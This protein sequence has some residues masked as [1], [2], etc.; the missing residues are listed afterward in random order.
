[1]R[2]IFKC[3]KVCSK[4]PLPFQRTMKRTISILLLFLGITLLAQQTGAKKEL[5]KRANE[6]YEL[7]STNP[8]KAFDESEKIIQEAQNSKNNEKAE[9]YGLITQ[10]AYYEMNSDFK[11]MIT[12]GKLLLQKAELYRLPVYQV[13][14]KTYLSEAYLSSELPDKS[15]SELKEG[16]KLMSKLSGNDA[17]S[18]ET[19]ANFLISYSNYYY[20]IGDYKSQLKY[21]KLAG[22]EFKKLTDKASRDRVLYIHY[23]NLGGVYND[24]NELDSAE[25]YLKLSLSEE[26]GYGRTDIQFNNLSFLGDVSIKRSDYENALS[27]LKKAEKLNGY[28]NFMNVEPLYDNIIHSYQHLKQT[29]SAK[30]YMIKRDSLKLSISEKQNNSLH[31][32]LKEKK[33]NRFNGYFYIIVSILIFSLIIT[34]F[35]IRKNIILSKQEKISQQY[36]KENHES[37]SGEDYSKL[38]KALK[39]N[40]PAFMFYFEET[41]PGFSS[42]LLE[43]NPKLSSSEIEFCAL[44]KLKIHTKEIARY[45]FIEPATVR[46]K[47]YL[48]KRKFSI[49]NDVDIYQWFDEF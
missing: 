5:L 22:T 9:L 2:N 43:I 46:N 40:D 18:V 12:V 3:F 39:E 11:N 21:V 13:I 19:K 14:A 6:N 30:L 23:S 47:K 20:F 17:V 49:P 28:K 24:L 35:T 44:L 32:L 34:F 26:K 25:H 29:D 41:F 8:E 38:L 31:S 36:L 37:P 7:L 16:M 42:K 45:K 10:C 27:Y 4:F 15:Y 1:M 33:E 48:V